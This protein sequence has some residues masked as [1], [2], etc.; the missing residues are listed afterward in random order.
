MDTHPPGI[1]RNGQPWRFVSPHGLAAH[2]ASTFNRR[3]SQSVNK[4]HNVEH[5]LVFTVLQ[6]RSSYKSIGED[7]A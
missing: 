5:L 1:P 7:L 2:Q 6:K 3:L 4:V